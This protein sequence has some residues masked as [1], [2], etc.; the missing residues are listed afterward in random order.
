MPKKTNVVTLPLRASN[1]AGIARHSLAKEIGGVAGELR[2]LNHIESGSE[3]MGELALA[4]QHLSDATALSVIAKNGT[5][6]DRAVVVAK[7]KRWFE[8]FPRD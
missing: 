4:L 3:S 1:D 5:D 8:E 7:L 6:E 2:P